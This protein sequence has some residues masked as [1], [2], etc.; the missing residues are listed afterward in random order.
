MTGRKLGAGYC[1]VV[2]IVLYDR[3]LLDL[4]CDAADVCVT[5]VPGSDRRSKGDVAAV[6]T[7]SDFVLDIEVA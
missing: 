3:F 5:A 2:C 4:T 6:C 7:A 1:T